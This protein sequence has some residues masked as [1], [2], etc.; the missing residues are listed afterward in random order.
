MKELFRIIRNCCICTNAR[1]LPG[2]W[3]DDPKII[4][5]TQN[6][7]NPHKSPDFDDN[8]LYE[9]LTEEEFLKIERIALE[10]CQFG[11]FLSFLLKDTGY[12]FDDISRFNVI[13]SPGFFSNEEMKHRILTCLPFLQRQLLH[14]MT[15]DTKIVALGRI[16]QNALRELNIEHLFLYHPSFLKRRYGTFYLKDI[17]EKFEEYIK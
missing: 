12:G 9:D 1:C 6:P 7:G 15:K 17:K 14:Q 2:Y 8:L 4:F 5:I 16:A 3:V 10:R 13:K 11:K